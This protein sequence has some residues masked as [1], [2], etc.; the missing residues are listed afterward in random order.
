[1]K[2]AKQAVVVAGAL[3]KITGGQGSVH[4]TCTWDSASSPSEPQYEINAYR[5]RDGLTCEKANL[6]AVDA[7]VVLLR[8][9]EAE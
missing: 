8:L 3:A 1:M 5:E 9:L 7:S 4:I 6:S 2:P